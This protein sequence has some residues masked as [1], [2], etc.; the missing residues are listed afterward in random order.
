MKGTIIMASGCS[1]NELLK[2]YLHFHKTYG[3]KIW[4]GVDFREE[5]QNT[6]A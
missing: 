5:A 2:L 3:H 6:K 1:Q 4:H